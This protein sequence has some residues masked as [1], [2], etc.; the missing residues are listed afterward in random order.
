M[1]IQRV[2]KRPVTVSAIELTAD[3]SELKLEEIADWSEGYYV[4]SYMNS[5]ARILI[6]TLE[7]EMAAVVGE[8]W[9]VQGVEGEFYA[10]EKG[11]FEKT[12][13]RD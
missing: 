10:V 3:L 7:G 12:Y 1:H 5:P 13:T 6:P 8:C 4:P 9:I 11:I 2:T